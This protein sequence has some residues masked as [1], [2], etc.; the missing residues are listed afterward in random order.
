ML[1]EII[2]VDCIPD[3][4]ADGGNSV[5]EWIKQLWYIYTMEHYSAV[6]KEDNFTLCDYMDGPGEHYAK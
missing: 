6:K 4:L 5:D 1:N 3:S 2:Y